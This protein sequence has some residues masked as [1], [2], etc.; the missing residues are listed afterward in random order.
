MNEVI[1]LLPHNHIWKIQIW[2]NY[3]AKL[4][5]YRARLVFSIFSS[6]FWF[7]S[8]PF[9]GFVCRRNLW[10]CH[11]ITYCVL[12]S[13]FSSLV[14]LFSTGLLIDLMI[15]DF[16]LFAQ[17]CS[18][19]DIL[20][21]FRVLS[22]CTCFGKPSHSVLAVVLAFHCLDC[23]LSRAAFLPAR[24]FSLRLFPSRIC[25]LC[26]CIMRNMRKALSWRLCWAVFCILIFF[27]P[28]QFSL[29]LLLFTRVFSS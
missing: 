21:Y 28:L 16:R 27:L 17:N 6:S 19:R 23:F 10:F 12:V 7:F 13:S 29:C 8:S 3:R 1:L 4:K 5:P 2:Q 20:C 14:E 11:L 26:L 24:Q 18:R 22:Q 9:S 25:S 15:G